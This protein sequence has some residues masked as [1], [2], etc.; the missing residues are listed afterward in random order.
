MNWTVN[1]QLAIQAPRGDILVS[2][3]AGSGKTATL[4]ERVLRALTRSDEPADISRML[5]VTFTNKAADELKEKIRRKLSAAL[6]ADPDNA[7]LRRCMLGLQS[8]KICTIHSFYGDVVRSDFNL[9]GISPRM[10]TADATEI[11]VLRRDIM[12]QVVDGYYEGVSGDGFEIE[13]AAGFFDNFLTVKPDT[14]LPELFL[15]LYDALSRFSGRAEFLRGNVRT[16]SAAAADYAGSPYHAQLILVAR[17]KLSSLLSAYERLESEYGADEE[18][19][20][21]CKN[22]VDDRIDFCRLALKTLGRGDDAELNALFENKKFA[23][24]GSKMQNEELIGRLKDLGEAFSSFKKFVK[25]TLAAFTPDDIS[26]LAKSSSELCENMYRLL[27]RFD[28]AFSEEKR[29]RRVIDFDDMER[30]AYRLIC[31]SDGSVSPTA[32]RLR[33][34]YDEIYIDEYQ[35]VNEIQDRIFEA[36]SDKNRFMVGDVKQSIYSFRGSRPELFSEYRAKFADGAAGRTILLSDNFRCGKP[37]VDFV[38]LLFGNIFS[39]D[40]GKLRYESG[41]ALVFSKKAAL[42]QD[43]RVRVVASENA[44]GEFAALAREI[45]RLLK[46]GTD[47]DGRPLRPEDITVLYR[48]SKQCR[49][50]EKALAGYGLSAFNASRDNLFNSPEVLL[51]LSLLCAIDNPLRD[52][53]LAAA[54]KSPVF[55][56]TLDELA[57][58]RKAEPSGTL[59]SAVRERAESGDEKCAAFCGR[60]DGYRQSSRATPTDRF[61]RYLYRDTGLLSLIYNPADGQGAQLREANLMLLYDFARTFE[62]GSFRGL[63]AFITHINDIIRRDA[64]FDC[65]DA[66]A[67]TGRVRIMTI[68]AS[69]GLEF[70]ACIV[71]GC[72]HGFNNDYLRDAFTLDP[73]MG[74]AV[75]LKLP[76]GRLCKGPLYAAVVS[77]IS[78]QTVREEARL[79]YVALTRARKYLVVTGIDKPDAAFSDAPNEEAVLGAGSFWR[80]L[81]AALPNEGDDCFEYE[82]F[83]ASEPEKTEEAAAKEAEADEAETAE[84]KREFLRRFDFVYPAFELTRLPRKVSVSGLS[85]SFLDESDPAFELDESE[86]TPQPP[87]MPSF[88]DGERAKKERA[89]LRGTATHTFMQFCDMSAAEESVENEAQR[90]VLEGFIPEEYVGLMYKEELKRFFSSPLY[91]RMKDCSARGGLMLREYRF[92]IGLPASEFTQNETLRGMYE[93]KNLLVQGVIDCFFENPDGSVTLVDYKTDRLN[94]TPSDIAAFA[95]RHRTQLSYYVQAIERLTLKKVSRRSLYSFCLGKEITD[96]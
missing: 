8:A 12:E 27:S 15:D 55:G 77:H 1:Q 41:D 85:P 96:K 29:Q 6:A 25:E 23:R 64:R 7:S 20:S 76:D 24:R 46:E 36:I 84:A 39:R 63:H 75:K 94:D 17:R 66:G 60:L 21:K 74:L 32:K 82:Y 91:S 50:A 37:V 42:R 92:N 54:M 3:A 86:R 58:I 89:A 40:G 80:L 14:A 47:D 10:R 35:D 53:T 49:A 62:A 34:R 71:A 65:A 51:A 22:A 31:P 26:S 61:V 73:D 19:I 81:K 69:K 57:L 72:S 28:A 67:Q 9:L 56:F 30:F 16:F 68:H 13:N 79:L 90:L 83:A 33:E 93:E 70:P 5:I 43:A 44:E 2:A 4:T 88:M 78:E 59:Y 18:Y 11:S 38:N 87:L 45:K 48:S 52:I 95:A